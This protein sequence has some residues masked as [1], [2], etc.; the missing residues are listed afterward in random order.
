MLSS[1]AK[2]WYVEMRQHIDFSEYRF[3][4]FF[5]Q[6]YHVCWQKKPE[7][8]GFAATCSI[9]TLA[10]QTHKPY[11]RGSL[12][13]PSG[14]YEKGGSLYSSESILGKG[15]YSG[16]RLVDGEISGVQLHV[17]F[18]GKGIVSAKNGSV[19]KI[20][21]QFLIKKSENGKVSTRCQLLD[22][23]WAWADTGQ[24]FRLGQ[25]LSSQS[26]Q[27]KHI[28]RLM[29]YSRIVKPKHKNESPE[30]RSPGSS[31]RS[32]RTTNKASDAIDISDSEEDINLRAN[33]SRVR[34]AT[35]H[36]AVWGAKYS[37]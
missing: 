17:L 23:F 18:F 35:I 13:L 31:S 19:K 2:P 4:M 29:P 20:V 14:P 5:L 21:F 27:S 28:T 34:E 36:L 33:Q 3:S 15:I 6:C 7:Y 9:S 10:P 26:T 25:R 16:S 22:T 12:H 1:P 37:D 24:E 30:P 8:S 32:S 11:T